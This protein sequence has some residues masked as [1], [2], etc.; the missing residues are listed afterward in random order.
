MS[1]PAVV[2][3]LPFEGAPSVR[4]DTQHEGDEV[5]LAEWIGANERLLALYLHAVE[6]SGEMRRAA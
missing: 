1:A 4:I 3:R 6:V 2:I 5:R